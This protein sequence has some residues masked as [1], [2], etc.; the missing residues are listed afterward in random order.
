MTV[1]ELVAKYPS[2]PWGVPLL[3]ASTPPDER[4][5]NVVVPYEEVGGE[6]V[7]LLRWASLGG[8]QECVGSLGRE[9]YHTIAQSIS[10]THARVCAC[11]RVCA[12]VC[13]CVRVCARV[14]VWEWV[15]GWEWVWR[16]FRGEPWGYE[17][18]AEVLDSQLGLLLTPI[19]PLLLPSP[20]CLF[21]LAKYGTHVHRSGARQH[22]E[23]HT[24]QALQI[25]PQARMPT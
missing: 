24:P 5:C 23:M 4:G 17:H 18:A 3:P 8:L 15:G 14:C 9:A 6:L 21:L 25:A 10:E 11:V 12:R 1:R 7:A 16:T 22:D 19:C 13:A 2:G 20:F